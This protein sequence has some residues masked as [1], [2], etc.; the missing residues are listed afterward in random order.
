MRK[1][2][3]PFL[4]ALALVAAAC[5]GRANPLIGVNTD[6]TVSG[7]T[8]LSSATVRIVDNA[9]QP[10]VVNI[11]RGGVVIWVWDSSATLHNVTFSDPLLAP[12]NSQTVSRGTHTVT[13]SVPGTFDYH[14]TIHSEMTGS[15]V[16]H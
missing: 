5:E 7:G 6:S 10:N 9:Y 2:A 3:G 14:C 15:V 13:F 16:V 12:Q 4:F 1:A 8:I 11:Q